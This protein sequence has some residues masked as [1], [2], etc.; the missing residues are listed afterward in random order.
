MR[1]LILVVV[2]VAAVGVVVLRQRSI[3]RCEQELAIGRHGDG[4]DPGRPT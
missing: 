2:A 4:T 3:D 1:R